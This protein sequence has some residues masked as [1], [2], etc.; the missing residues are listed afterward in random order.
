MYKRIFLIDLEGLGVGGASDNEANTLKH[1][2]DNRDCNLNILEKL[3]LLNLVDRGISNFKGYHGLIIPKSEGC[4]SFSGLREM[5]GIIS[6]N[7]Y[8]Y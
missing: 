6:S 3:G 2:L 4:D 8:E 1:I 7:K 5:M